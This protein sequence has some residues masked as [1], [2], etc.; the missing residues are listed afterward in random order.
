M[1]PFTPT[2][3][4]SK[5]YKHPLRVYQRWQKARRIKQN[6]KAQ[7]K[8]E[9][10]K[11]V[12]MSCWPHQS[13]FIIFKSTAST[14]PSW[15]ERRRDYPSARRQEC[16]MTGCFDVPPR[17]MDISSL[18]LSLSLRGKYCITVLAVYSKNKIYFLAVSSNNISFLN[19]MFN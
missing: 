2:F 15:S 7:I 9:A 6:M 16:L 10:S 12:Q 19:G 8:K 5:T 3:N 4:S 13:Q 18:C 1:L 14:A 11:W 17:A